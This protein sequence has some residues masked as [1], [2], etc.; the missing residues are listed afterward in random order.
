MSDWLQALAAA[1]EAPESSQA[2]IARRLGISASTVN[3]VLHGKYQG[4][5][6]RIEALVRGELMDE[7]LIC[8]VAGEITKSRCQGIQ[9]LPKAATNPQRLAL[10]HAC[11]NGCPHSRIRK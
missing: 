2:A 3:Q 10:W 1:C 6:A 5:M 7:T 11:R 9:K 8:P 4:D